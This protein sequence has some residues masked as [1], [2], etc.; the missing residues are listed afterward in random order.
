MDA[1]ANNAALQ[2]R[3][4]GYD[5]SEKIRLDN[6]SDVLSCNLADLSLNSRGRIVEINVRVKAVCP[7]KRTAVAVELYELDEEEAEHP[8]GMKVFSLPAHNE[9][10]NRDILIENI[11]FAL[12]EDTNL[13]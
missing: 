11:R 8:R 4:S 13:S 12:P 6:C 5:H 2:Y 9:S 3:L 7:G 10:G 1:F